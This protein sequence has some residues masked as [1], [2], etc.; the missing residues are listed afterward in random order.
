MYHRIFILGVL[1]FI[2]FTTQCSDSSVN[3]N[4]SL[5]KDFIKGSVESTKERNDLKDVFFT[6]SQF[7][8]AQEEN[9]YIENFIKTMAQQDSQKRCSSFFQSSLVKEC[10]ALQNTL[11]FYQ[12]RL[13]PEY[14]TEKYQFYLKNYLEN[15]CTGFIHMRL[16]HAV[17]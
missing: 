1:I 15:N 7:T 13:S 4:F 14:I 16:N 11:V 17:F 8:P 6:P 10:P 12:L 2:N 9:E 3:K 5:S